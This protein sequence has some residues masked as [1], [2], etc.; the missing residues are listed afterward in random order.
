MGAELERC[1]VLFG[2]LIGLYDDV[3]R[4]GLVCERGGGLES[5]FLPDLRRADCVTKLAWRDVIKTNSS[6]LQRER[7]GREEAC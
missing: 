3:E 6:T 7:G 4:K 5:H 1:G 2:V